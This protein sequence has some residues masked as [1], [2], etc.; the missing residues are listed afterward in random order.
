MSKAQYA[1]RVI[2]LL[3]Y[4]DAYPR[5]ATLK[6]IYEHHGWPQSS[7]SELL[8]VL[9]ECG[10]LYRDSAIR[11]RPT[12]RAAMLAASAG[13]G[14]LR[15][16]RL[17]GLMT[18]LAAQAG[19]SVALIGQVGQEAQVFGC[20]PGQDREAGCWGERLA[21][22]MKTP[23]HR[24]AA[25]WLLLSA[26]GQPRWRGVLHRLLAEAPPEE[27]FSLSAVSARVEACQLQGH[28]AGP[29]GFGASLAFCGV[30]APSG[31][32]DQPM[33]LGFVFDRSSVSPSALTPLLQAALAEQPAQSAAP[34]EP[35]APRIPASNT[36]SALAYV[37]A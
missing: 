26:L 31:P 32:A 14:A 35:A 10:L 7:T 6:E 36:A 13:P 24:S 21:S 16:G 25:G 29:A 15:Q 22:G 33:V 9:V 11:F 1:R 18:R 19:Q 23:L 27:K 2:Q 37:A 17:L 8:A 3:E 5:P 12:P 20:R 4:F 30:L 28:V 34:E